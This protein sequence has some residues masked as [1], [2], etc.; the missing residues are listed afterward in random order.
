LESRLG[1]AGAGGSLDR[2][3]RMMLPRREAPSKPDRATVLNRT[4]PPR[5]FKANYTM[6]ARRV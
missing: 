2:L 1:G 6:E 4:K 5:W 3:N